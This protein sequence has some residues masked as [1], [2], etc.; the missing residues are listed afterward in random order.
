MA[1][2]EEHAENMAFSE[3]HFIARKLTPEVHA[4][5][6]DNLPQDW[7]ESSFVQGSFEVTV[8]MAR[9]MCEGK[10]F[11]RADGTEVD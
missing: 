5:P 3:E 2:D 9:E 8:A 6:L 1:E 7:R 11:Y 10:I 4:Q